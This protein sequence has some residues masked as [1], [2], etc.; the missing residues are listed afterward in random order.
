MELLVYAAPWMN[1]ITVILENVCVYVG[2]NFAN[3]KQ[4]I[5]FPGMWQ[6][7]HDSTHYLIWIKE[8]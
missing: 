8:G 6:K 4:K 2:F 1:D 7:V 3:W 5:S